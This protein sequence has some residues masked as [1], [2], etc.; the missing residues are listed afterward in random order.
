MQG[1]DRSSL[2]LNT[3]NFCSKNSIRK[4]PSATRK[5]RNKALAFPECE[6]G[7]FFHEER[8]VSYLPLSSTCC[9]KGRLGEKKYQKAKLDFLHTRLYQSRHD[10]TTII[11]KEKKSLL[12]CWNWK[13]YNSKKKKKKVI[14]SII[15][16][17]RLKIRSQVETTVE[18]V[19]L[20]LKLNES[21]SR[22]ILIF[23]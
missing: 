19:K 8:Q 18:N 22:K 6:L 4:K 11:L 21:V 13:S 16:D 12:A 14:Y 17:K 2:P 1:R 5:A 10:L 3:G 20:K 7:M 9:T 15:T 23:T